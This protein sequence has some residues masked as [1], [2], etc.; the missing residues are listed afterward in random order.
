ML[1]SNGEFWAVCTDFEDDKWVARYW[2][3]TPQTEYVDSWI[4]VG[5][6]PTREEAEAA[7]QLVF[8]MGLYYDY[9]AKA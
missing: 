8:D 2:Y 5:T 1:P 9:R 4:T 6:Y 7:A 3:Y